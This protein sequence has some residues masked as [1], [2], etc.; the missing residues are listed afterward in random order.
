MHVDPCDDGTHDE[1]S[2]KAGSI[3][4]SDARAVGIAQIS[5]PGIECLKPSNECRV[6]W[7]TQR[8]TRASTCDVQPFSI[9]P[10]MT[11]DR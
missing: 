7:R 8:D 3:E 9:M 6:I 5:V 2:N 11:I 1:A 10:I 4:K